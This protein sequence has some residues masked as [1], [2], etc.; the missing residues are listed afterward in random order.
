MCQ[1]LFSF[2]RYLNPAESLT[3]NQECVGSNPT[4][5]ASYARQEDTCIFWP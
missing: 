1:G 3:V 5:A 2:A 4:C